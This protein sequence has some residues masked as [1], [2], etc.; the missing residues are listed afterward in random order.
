MEKQEELIEF[1]AVHV[2]VRP[3]CVCPRVGKQYEH[4]N[5][6]NGVTWRKASEWAADRGRV[7]VCERERE[8]E[9]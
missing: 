7:C 4:P 2:P 3:M 9:R 5:K 6:E 1:S 8:R